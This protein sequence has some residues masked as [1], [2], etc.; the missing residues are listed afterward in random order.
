MR[1]VNLSRDG[2]VSHLIVESFV[3]M[4]LLVLVFVMVLIMGCLL[5]KLQS[6]VTPR[7]IGLKRY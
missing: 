4:L 6:N 7:H 5:V 3:V 2:L 1:T